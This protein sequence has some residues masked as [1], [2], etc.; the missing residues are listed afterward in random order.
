ME[1]RTSERQGLFNECSTNLA[2]LQQKSRKSMVREMP[3]KSKFGHGNVI[4][5]KKRPYNKWIERTVRGRHALCLTGSI[6]VGLIAKVAPVPSGAVPPGQP[7][8]PCSPL[9]HTLSG[10]GNKRSEIR[11][12]RSEKSKN[13]HLDIG[14]SALV[15]FYW[16]NQQMETKRIQMRWSKLSQVVKNIS[17]YLAQRTFDGRN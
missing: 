9:I 11:Y 7:L 8:R 15:K 10:L 13:E 14:L 16:I 3:K 12:K 2:K 1:L 5:I 4:Q 6:R 17:E